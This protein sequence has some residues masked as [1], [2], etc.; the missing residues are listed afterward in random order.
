M[1]D[2]VRHDVT[3]RAPTDSSRLRARNGLQPIRTD[4]GDARLRAE[5]RPV[6]SGGRIA[7][8]LPCCA[9]RPPGGQP[10]SPPVHLP[11]EITP[12]PARASRAFDVVTARPVRPP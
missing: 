6:L 8:V 11:A 10:A 2:Q 1:P 5:L 7:H 12:L 3:V 4:W 9:H